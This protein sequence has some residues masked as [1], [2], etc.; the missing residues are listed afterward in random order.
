VR[1]VTLDDGANFVLAVVNGDRVGTIC[2][3][4]RAAGGAISPLCLS[5]VCFS[6]RVDPLPKLIYAS[7][8][9][10]SMR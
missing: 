9:A 2:R 10:F 5:S 1:T 4:D 7:T 8:V 6:F 3:R